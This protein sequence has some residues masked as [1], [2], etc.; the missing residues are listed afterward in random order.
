MGM[1]GVDG[2]GSIAS[3]LIGSVQDEIGLQDDED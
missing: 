1:K 2:S 3:G